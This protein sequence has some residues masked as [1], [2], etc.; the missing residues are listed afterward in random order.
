M[1]AKV[2]EGGGR[3]EESTL[4]MVLRSKGRQRVLVRGAGLLF[5]DVFCFVSVWLVRRDLYLDDEPPGVAELLQSNCT[6]ACVQTAG[7]ERCWQV[8][9]RRPLRQGTRRLS[10]VVEDGWRRLLF[11]CEVY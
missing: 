8:S 4:R 7:P 1:V 10:E 5:A 6:P 9:C 2:E 11:C 3:G